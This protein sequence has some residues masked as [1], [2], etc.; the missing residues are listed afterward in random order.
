MV[1]LRNALFGLAVSLLPVPALANGTP[2][3]NHPDYEAALAAFIETLAH[4]DP[5]LASID[6]RPICGTR[7]CCVAVTLSIAAEGD[8]LDNPY[9][10][11]QRS[12]SAEDALTGGIVYPQWC[13]IGIGPDQ[14]GGGLICLNCEFP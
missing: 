4:A 2:S 9:A 14:C 13:S 8:D 12:L 3:Q 6:C 5:R 11:G 7:Y 1:V 10:R